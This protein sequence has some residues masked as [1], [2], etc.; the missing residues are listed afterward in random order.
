MRSWDYFAETPRGCLTFTSLAFVLRTRTRWGASLLGG[1]VLLLAT[2]STPLVVPASASS[3]YLCTGYTACQQAGYSHAGYA[4]AGREMWWGMFAGHNCTNYVAYRLVKGGMSNTRPWSGSG[5][6]WNWG[7]VKADLTDQRPAV[8]AVAWWRKGTSWGGSSGH[9]AY[10]ERVISPTEIIVSEDSWGGD[11]HWRRAVKGTSGWPSGF[12]HFNDAAVRA[13]SAPSVS[14]T[15]TVGSRLTASSGSW[16]PAADV[17]HRWFADGKPIAGATGSSY[18]L[19]AGDL[20]RRITVRVKAVSSGYVPGVATAVAGTVARGTLRNPDAPAV[21][22]TPQVDEVL[23]ATPGSWEPGGVETS[24][25][26]YADGRPVAGATGWRLRLDQQHIGK[27]LTAQVTATAPG[28]ERAV[29]RSSQTSPVVAGTIEVREPFAIGGVPRSG[30]VLT[31]RAGRVSPSDARVLYTWRRDGDLVPGATGETYVLGRD[32]VGSRISLT[33]ELLRTGYQT[34][35]DVLQLPG[36]VTTKP[37]LQVVAK[38]R[39]GRAVIRVL[40]TADGVAPPSGPLKVRVGGR[41]VAGRLVDGRDRL[42]VTGVKPGRHDVVVRYAGT[43]V[44]TAARAT[45]GVRVLRPRG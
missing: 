39:P 30:R 26:W 23:E 2:L 8:G 4:R 9:V 28:Y 1:L 44:V 32:D 14:G 45:T 10:I 42:V 36:R 11:F 5:M 37:D 31:V 38:G 18:T 21:R 20:G 13:T 43:E 27:R 16:K 15:T 17:R 33:V 19:G 35:T 41:T 22:G 3:T 12:V 40:A 34:R 29:V 25:Q 6:A 24:V 7:L